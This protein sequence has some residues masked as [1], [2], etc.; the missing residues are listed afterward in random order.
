MPA[1]S[2][3]PCECATQSHFLKRRF[4]PSRAWLCSSS[5]GSLHDFSRVRV[6]QTPV[7]ASFAAARATC[8]VSTK[9]P[10]TPCHDSPARAPSQPKDAAPMWVNSSFPGCALAR[11]GL[12]TACAVLMPIM[13]SPIILCVLLCMAGGCALWTRGL[14]GARRTKFRPRSPRTFCILG[15][16]RSPPA[17]ITRDQ[18]WHC[19]WPPHLPCSCPAR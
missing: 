11:R 8:H 15:W 6:R 19:L 10:C 3:M 2:S 4:Y 17:I 14:A 18:L 16:S 5:L 9:F 13:E 1:K 12:R 7:R